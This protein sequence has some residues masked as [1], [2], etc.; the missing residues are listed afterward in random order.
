MKKPKIIFVIEANIINAVLQ[1]G[2]A[3]YPETEGKPRK[4]VRIITD[5]FKY[6]GIDQTR[7]EYLKPSCPLTNTTA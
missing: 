5:H 2:D 7:T 1:H 3:L 6:F 4:F